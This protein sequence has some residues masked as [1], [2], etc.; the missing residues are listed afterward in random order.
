MV[1]QISE[2]VRKGAS[3]SVAMEEH[4]KAFTKLYVSMVRVGEEAGVLPKVM[5][6]LASLL[7]HEDEIRGEVLAAVAYPVFVLGFGIFTVTILLTVVMPKLF[8]MLQEML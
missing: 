4:P 6:D 3:L 1:V 7:E 8:T 5:S 2:S